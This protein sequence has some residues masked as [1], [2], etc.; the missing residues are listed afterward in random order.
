MMTSPVTLS[1]VTVPVLPSHAVAALQVKMPTKNT[2]GKV[3]ALNRLQQDENA[4]VGDVIDTMCVFDDHSFPRAIRC[5]EN[6]FI[7]FM[8]RIERDL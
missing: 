8:S 3:Q 7:V 1:I 5:I 4:D 2:F 6:L